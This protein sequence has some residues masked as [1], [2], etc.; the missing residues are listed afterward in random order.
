MKLECPRCGG[1]LSISVVEDNAMTICDGCGCVRDMTLRV[2]RTEKED[3][4]EEN[5]ADRRYTWLKTDEGLDWLRTKRSMGM[6]ITD[7][8][9]ELGV[10]R[11]SL[12][13]WINKDDKIKKIWFG[14]NE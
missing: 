11:A 3:K 2:Y 4:R 6:T 12:Y 5:K 14:V 10:S 9:N 8:A 13:N 1:R 7:V